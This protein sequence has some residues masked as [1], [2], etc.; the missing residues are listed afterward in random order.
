[1]DAILGRCAGWVNGETKAN[2]AIHLPNRSRRSAVA[3]DHL[4]AHA[5]SGRD[6]AAGRH[7]A[8]WGRH[9]VENPRARARRSPDPRLDAFVDELAGSVPR[10]PVGPEHLGFSVPLRLAADGEL[11]LI[12]TITSFATA[13]DVTLAEL[14]LEAVLPAG[15]ELAG[16]RRA[17]A[18]LAAEYRRALD[19]PPAADATVDLLRRLVGALLLRLTRLSHADSDR[20]AGAAFRAFRRELEHSFAT[21]RTTETYA[22]RLGFSAR[23]LNRACLAATGRSAKRLIDDRVAL[24]AKRLLV[25]T[26]L[27]AAAISRRPGFT[28]PTNF[29]RFFARTTGDTPEAFR[30]HERRPPRP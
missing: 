1:M 12:T 15:G 29:G 3:D 7:L 21:T 16:L 22:S 8:E 4:A 14:R 11:R 27:P 23:T 30:R 24:E 10:T 28:E 5:P 26:D 19:D 6:G 9:V 2:P 17:M 18:E 20:R 25:H 13:V